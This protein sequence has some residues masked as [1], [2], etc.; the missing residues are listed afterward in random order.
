MADGAF[1]ALL[2][3]RQSVRTGDPV[4]V[5]P[6]ESPSF[7]AP[8]PVAAL[9]RAALDVAV[10][11]ELSELFG[12]L[13]LRTLGQVAERAVQLGGLEFMI[14]RRY[15]RSLFNLSHDSMWWDFTTGLALEAGYQHM[16]TIKFD[17]LERPEPDKKPEPDEELLPA[18]SIN[19]GDI[20]LSGFTLRFGLHVHF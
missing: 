14:P 4:V 11:V 9:T 3:A 8:F 15:L 12:R 1:A 18:D 17:A 19:Y 6:G 20:D 7:L 2:A 10:P 16:G 5:E 13:G